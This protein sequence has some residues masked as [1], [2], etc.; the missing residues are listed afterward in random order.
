MATWYFQDG[1]NSMWS[2]L[3]NW[4]DQDGGVGNNPTV[5]PWTDASTAADILV[6]SSLMTNPP[7]IDVE[8]GSSDSSWA[9]TGTCDIGAI[10]A[11]NTIYDG[12]YTG[13]H[14]WNNG[15]IDGGTFTGGDFSGDGTING[16]TFTGDTSSDGNNI[17]GGTFTSSS[18]LVFGNINGGTWDVTTLYAYGSDCSINYLPSTT[19][20]TFGSNSINVP[21]CYATVILNPQYNGFD[22]SGE[23]FGLV[24]FTSGISGTLRGTYHQDLDMSSFPN[25]RSWNFRLSGIFLGRVFSTPPGSSLSGTF[26]GDVTSQSPNYNS[27]DNGPGYFG[28]F[29]GNIRENGR[30]VWGG[31]TVYGSVISDCQFTNSDRIGSS[32]SIFYGP[33]QVWGCPPPLYYAGSWIDSGTYYGPVWIDV[34]GCIA[35]GTFY[36]SAVSGS[37]ISG[38]DFY[39]SLGWGGPDFVYQVQGGFLSGTVHNITSTVA[40]GKVT[41]SFNGVTYISKQLTQL[42]IIGTGGL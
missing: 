1:A 32:D 7:T 31:A 12:T 35:G 16:G 42:D 2:N 15:T 11:Y 19:T 8:I 14:F 21:T 20:V 6:Q 23:F 9:I 24:T 37:Y 36:G 18:R 13:D 28:T 10:N 4:F 38:G 22:M 27:N 26:Y 33:V 39:G 34:C 40:D 5:A 25:D 30:S 17:N 41:T 29:Y 3:S